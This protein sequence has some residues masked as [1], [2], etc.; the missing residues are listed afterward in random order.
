S[1]LMLKRC[2]DVLVAATVL[3]LASPLLLLIA[4]A[5][6]LTS[7]GS[8]L[9]TQRRIG[10]DERPFRMLKFRTMYVGS[11]AMKEGLEHLNEAATP[12]FK[13]AR[14]PRVTPVGR[15][16]RRFSLDEIPQLWNV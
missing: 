15:F 11:E 7:R 9:F 10:R 5:I 8:V 12:M 16:L 6:K 1:S 13:I 3:A 2:I 14:D 4:A